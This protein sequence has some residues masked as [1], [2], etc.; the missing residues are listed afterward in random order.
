[1]TD[2][3]LSISD[4]NLSTCWERSEVVAVEGEDGNRDERLVVTRGGGDGGGAVKKE[5]D[6]IVLV[7]IQGFGAMEFM[8]RLIAK[9]ERERGRR[10]TIQWDIFSRI[11]SQFLLFIENIEIL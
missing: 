3:D 9:T 2:L 10:R 8:V 7:L 5:E 1:M 6:D 11:S 4:A